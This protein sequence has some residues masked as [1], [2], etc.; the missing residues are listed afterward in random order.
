MTRS[1]VLLGLVAVVVAGCVTVVEPTPSP[2][3]LATQVAV[4]PTPTPEPTTQTY[5]IKSGDNLNAIAQR[6]GLTVGQL[7]AANPDITDPNRIRVGQALII[8]P[9][10]APD[11]GPDSAGIGDASDDVVDLAGQLVASQSY[12]DITGFGAALATNR[13][14]QIEL[15]MVN[16]PPARLDPAVEVVTYTV[17]IDVDGDGQPDFRLIY[18]NDVEGLTGF[19]PSL[20]NRLTGSVKSGDGFPGTVTVRNSTITFTVRRSALGA[21]RAYAM[22]ATVERVYSPGG[23]GDPEGDNS[24]DHAPDQQWPRPNPRWVEVGGV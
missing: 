7:L 3:P 11:T 17:V 22:A 5:V 24:V 6:F 9:P 1:P 18:S 12:A 15:E 10:D 14:L 2:E 20:E 8:P 16:G 13:R 21:P 23:V 4:A 19:Q